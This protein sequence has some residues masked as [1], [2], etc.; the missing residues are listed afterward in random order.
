L[1]WHCLA[2]GGRPDIFDMTFGLAKAYGLALR[3]H[4]RA[5]AATLQR[6]GLPTSDHNLLDSY[7][8]GAVDKAARCAQLL[9]ELPPG[10][11]E[12]A[13][14]PSL[15]NAEAQALEPHSWQIRK[16]DF[17]FLISPE[18]RRIVE[19]EGIILLDYRALQQMWSRQA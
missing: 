5:L 14:H 11:S 19:E 4:D 12:W 2:D 17:D 18:A 16:A 15:G 8:L 6:G 7:R 10:L 1:D 9:R 3:I 13:V